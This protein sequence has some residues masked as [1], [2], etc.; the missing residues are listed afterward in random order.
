MKMG[1]K[2]SALLGSPPAPNS[3]IISLATCSV[4]WAQMSM[5]LL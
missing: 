4:T 1:L 2:D 3:F 5:T